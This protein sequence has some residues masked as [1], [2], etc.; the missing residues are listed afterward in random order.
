MRTRWT[1][2]IGY[3]A[4]AWSLLY[5]VLGVYWW[6]GGAGFPF[7]VG[8]PELR[9]E[10]EDALVQSLLGWATPEVAGPVIAAL[11]FAG[12]LAGVAMA[13]RWSGG[14]ARWLL[15]AFAWTVAFGL[16]V[17]I[18]DSRA[19]ITVAYTP[20]L[21]VGKLFFGWPEQAEWGDLFRLPRLNLLLCM[22]AG[23]AWA[24]TADRKSVV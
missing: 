14:P 6:F 10:G 3:A 4:A 19:L 9:G 7:G 22:V 21:V 11:G 13:R 8:D 1:E 23:F 24:L 5:G 15:P 12:A 2:W 18:Q 17:L 20:I 16:T